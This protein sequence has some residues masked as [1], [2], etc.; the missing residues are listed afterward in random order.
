MHIHNDRCMQT[1]EHTHRHTHTHTHSLRGC[2]YDAIGI[3]RKP[4]FA[5][6]FPVL[7]RMC[8]H[9]VP[10]LF[11]TVDLSFIREGRLALSKNYTMQVCVCVYVCACVCVCLCIHSFS[12]SSERGG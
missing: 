8:P 11:D 3:S 4:V 9:T 1:C 6:W 12:H 5:S 2:P 10:I 7:R